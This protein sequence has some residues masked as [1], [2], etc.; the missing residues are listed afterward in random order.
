L[1][2]FAGRR[3][4][5]IVSSYSGDTEETVSAY[6]DARAKGARIVAV[7][8]GGR[9][10]MMA[11]RDGFPVIT[12]PV[13]LPPRC[14]LGYSFFSILMLLCAIGVVGD[15]SEDMDETIRV[16]G[17]LR[18]K[19]LAWHVKGKNN[20]AKNI[21]GRLYRK[22]VVIYSGQER[23]DAVAARWRGQ[24]AENSKTMASSHVIPEMN[25]NE[26]VG[27]GYP[28][29]LIENSAVIMLKD[30]GDHPRISLRMD[31]TRN[32]I[33]RSGVE[34]T[35]LESMGESALARMFSLAYVG[36]FVSFYL[37]ILNG[38]DPTPVRMIDYLKKELAKA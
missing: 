33:R 23:M 26:I 13:G 20:I 24:L 27:W 9:I 8:S 17:D 32:I 6:K 29:R 14:A 3:S 37:A 7:T 30:K 31:I 16:M 15:K 12:M 11:G 2:G 28:G 10:G 4:L 35:E 34:V 1:P 5:V 18:S 22:Y 19:R 38:I 25:H 36:D 21:A